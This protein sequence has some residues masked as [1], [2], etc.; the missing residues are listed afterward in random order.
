M[1]A[2]LNRHYWNSESRTDHSVFIGSW[3]KNTATRPPRDV[4]L[5]FVLPVEV[6]YRFE[7]YIWNKQSALLQE[8]KSVLGE[9]YPDTDMSGDGQIVLVNFSSYNVKRHK[10]FSKIKKAAEDANKKRNAI[11]HQD[12]FCNVGES[13]ETI[14]KSRTFIETVIGV[15]QAG[16]KLKDRKQQ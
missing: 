4:D 7:R 12:E 2:C 3:G 8:V 14:A 9:T 13:K 5:Y 6:Y 10:L 1:I 16:F 15:Y 11:V